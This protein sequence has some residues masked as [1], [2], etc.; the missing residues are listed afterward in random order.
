MTEQLERRNN[1]YLPCSFC[2]DP[3]E[4]LTRENLGGHQWYV[5]GCGPLHAGCYGE[6]YPP[7]KGR[8]ETSA[9][10]NLEDFGILITEI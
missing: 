1:S 4:G 2:S 6:V 9:R 8:E 5:D 3:I 7:S 10:L